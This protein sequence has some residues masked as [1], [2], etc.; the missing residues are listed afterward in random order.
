MQD[1]FDRN[2][3]ENVLCCGGEEREGGIRAVFLIL[4][5]ASTE[6]DSMSARNSARTTRI[7]L[8]SCYAILSHP[9]PCLVNLVQRILCRKVASC[10]YPSTNGKWCAITS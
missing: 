2:G 8:V 6:A 5:K 7:V 4:G 10:D 3:L 1:I 9:L